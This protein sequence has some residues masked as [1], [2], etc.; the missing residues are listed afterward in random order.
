[1]GMMYHRRIIKDTIDDMFSLLP[2]IHP[3]NQTYAREYLSEI[4]QIV[5]TLVLSFEG[6]REYA[7][8]LRDKFGDYIVGEEERIRKNLDQLNYRVDSVETLYIILGPGRLEKV[9]LCSTFP[10]PFV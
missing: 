3:R 5:M 4:W 1:M 2:L 8:V 6:R 10:T 7:K 9:K